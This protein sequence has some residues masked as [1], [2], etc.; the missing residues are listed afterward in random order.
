MEINN[1]GYDSRTYSI[2]H[3]EVEGYVCWKNTVRRGVR[4]TFSKLEYWL[5]L[6]IN[7]GV[8]SKW[9]GGGLTLGNIEIQTPKKKWVLNVSTLNAARS[10]SL[11]KNYFFLLFFPPR[12]SA[13]SWALD[14]LPLFIAIDGWYLRFEKKRSLFL[15]SFSGSFTG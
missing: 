14:S 9:G 2:A 1:W 6:P 13:S 7:S 3:K 12:R 4:I 15:I 11:G 5:A 8:G 10:N